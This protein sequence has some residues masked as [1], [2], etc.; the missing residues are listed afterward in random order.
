MPGGF[1]F[2]FQKILDVKEKLERALEIQLGS[3]DRLILEQ[4]GVLAQ[5]QRGKQA[6]LQ[7]IRN[8]RQRADLVENARCTAYLRHVRSRMERSRATLFEL[9]QKREGV[10]QEL[11]RTAQSRRVLEKYRNRLRAE[12]MAAME[13]AE[14]RVTEVHSIRKFSRA[15]G[16]L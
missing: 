13:K 10:R 11:Q 2:R 8:A 7:E 14:E 6:I 1:R 15:E 16:M 3:L 4:E 9:R 12:F 5:W